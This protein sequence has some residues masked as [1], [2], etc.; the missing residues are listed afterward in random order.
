MITRVS[1][2]TVFVN[3]QD[4][5]VR[6]YTETLGFEKRMDA[7]FN[8]FRWVTVAPP[9]Q[10][11]VELVLLEPAAVFEPDVAAK[12]EELMKAGKLGGCVLNTDDCQGDYERLRAKGVE[13]K[14]A[15]E[16]K[17]FGVQATLKDNSNNWFSLTQTR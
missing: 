5:A 13:F 17:P 14:S 4:N 11:E 8:N 6:F 12:F 7:T 15:P 2:V 3:N 16:K 9:K 1:H 10:Q